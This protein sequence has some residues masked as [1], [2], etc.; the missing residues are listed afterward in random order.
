MNR[1]AAN[2]DVAFED[3]E[4]AWRF[5]NRAIMIWL[6]LEHLCL[7]IKYVHLNIYLICSVFCEVQST[8]IDTSSF[9][10]SNNYCIHKVDKHK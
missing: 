3:S 7:I 8:F 2:E 10:E 9:Q 5:W 1:V 6:L 4:V